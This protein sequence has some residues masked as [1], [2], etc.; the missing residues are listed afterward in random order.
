MM[1]HVV[2]KHAGVV[3]VDLQ[4]TDGYKRLVANKDKEEIKQ[5]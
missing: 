2:K 5:D 3:V 1:K 4:D